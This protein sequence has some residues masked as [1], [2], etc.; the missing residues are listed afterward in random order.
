MAVR[1]IAEE[2]SVPPRKTFDEIQSVAREA[3]GEMADRRLLS[4]FGTERV[5]VIGDPE[6]FEEIVEGDGTVAYNTYVRIGRRDPRLVLCIDDEPCDPFW[7][8]LKVYSEWF[9]HTNHLLCA[10][11]IASDVM[12]KIAILRKELEYGRLI[13]TAVDRALGHCLRRSAAPVTELV[14][15]AL[16]EVERRFPSPASLKEDMTRAR[17]IAIACA[18]A[19]RGTLL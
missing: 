3:M 2:V 5:R 16:D 6:G 14:D 15:I 12:L 1:V 17:L 18:S 9:A 10:H 8:G 4:A 19:S 7:F 13:A 11:S